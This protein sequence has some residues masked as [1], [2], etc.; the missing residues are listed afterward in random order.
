MSRKIAVIGAGADAVSTVAQLISRRDQ[1]DSEYQDDEITWIRDC[2]H[3]IDN[4]G[5]QV[6]TLWLT[7]IATNTTI[8]TLD[9]H[10]RFDATQKLGLKFIGFGNRIDKNFFVMFDPTEISM[11]IDEGKFVEFYWENVQNQHFNI[12]LVDKRVETIGFSQEDKKAYIDGEEFDFIVDC[13]RGG[14]WDKE[15]YK[16]ALYNPTDTKLTVNRKIPGDWDYTAYIATEHGY[17]T[18][19][20][21]QDAQTWIY[22]YDSDI[23]TEEEAVEDFNIHC[24]VKK[25][26]SYKKTESDHKVSVYCINKNKMYARCGRALGMN[27]DL[28]GF[29]SYVETDLG[30]ALG[31]FI[32]G[33]DENPLNNMQR[34][35]IEDRWRDGQIDQAAVMAFYLQFGSKYRHSDFWVQSR[36]AACRLLEDKDLHSTERREV[37]EKLDDIPEEENIRLDYFRYQAEA[38]DKY[39]LRQRMTDESDE[40]YRMLGPYQSFCQAV[41]GLGA[42][43][44]HKYPLMSPLWEPSEKSGE[45]VLDSMMDGHFKKRTKKK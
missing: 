16:D 31:E 34:L 14:L 17:L 18:G 9:F 12:N 1:Q 4:F 39:F 35:E 27:D 28:T 38:D 6:N 11:H 36:E 3:K 42:P 7:V 5:V 19:V 21:T 2:S 26:C 10:K 24:A 37:Y 13:V 25:H 45:I 33:D 8:S 20:P 15:S 44:A 32:F 30:E 29:R 43:Y 41:Y 40:P 23:T 22:S